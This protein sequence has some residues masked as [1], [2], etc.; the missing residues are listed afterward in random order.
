MS[1]LFLTT[2]PTHSGKTT[3]G[4]ELCAT[5]GTSSKIIHVDND[6]VDEF[7]QKNYNNLRTDK[8]ILATRT[9]TNPDLR[10]LIP[11]LITDYALRENYSVIATASHPRHIIRE[12]YY[13]IARNNNSKVVLLHFKVSE[14][15]ILTRIQNTHRS[16]HILDTSP[17]D[18]TSSPRVTRQA[19]KYF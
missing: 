4:R 17:H 10:L 1:L 6:V 9:P 8:A 19:E 13:A 3:F 15:E 5:L 14:A 16:T 12:S 7:I 2:G 18:S 11:Q